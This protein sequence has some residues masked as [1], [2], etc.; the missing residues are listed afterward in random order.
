MTI[1]SK[2]V[3]A[4]LGKHILADGYEPVMDMEKSHGSW[5]V[6]ERDG[7][8]YLDMFSMFASGAVGYNHPDILAGKDRLAAAALYKPTLSDI[9]NVQYAEFVEA[10]SNTAIP[11]YLPHTFFIEG[12]ALGV[13]NA[14][15]VAFDWKVRK[16]MEN[17]KGEKGGKI[18]HFKQ[19][20][21]GRTGYT[22]SL[23][24][25]TDPRK[26]M[27]FPKFDWPRIDIPKLSFPITDIVLENVEKNE[28]IAIDQIKSAISNNPDDIAALIIEPIQGEGGDN[29]FRDNFFV[30]LRQ[31]CDENEMLFIMDEVQTGIGITG[32]WWAHQHNSVKPDIIS[33]GKKTQVCGLLAGKRVEEVDKNVFSESSRINSTFGGNLAD[34]V[35][36]HIILEIIEKENLIENAKNMGAVLKKELQFLSE[37][38]PAYVTNPRGLGL[39]AAFDLPSQTERDKVID[40]LLK[41]KLLMLPS[42]DD[43]IRFRPHLNVTSEDLKTSID[44]IK[45][46]IK[47]TL[48]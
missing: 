35:R 40:G 7:S 6:D 27:Y 23:T 29:H 28:K 47:A 34:M 30:A 38:F 15:K 22:L 36:F 31:L 11:E 42:G 32:K 13:E 21:H 43:A 46:T 48:N 10:F 24:N 14:L 4:T 9:Y 1:D 19:A 2:N 20:F 5:L 8:E 41:N 45:S 44:I 3:R 16:N 39:F 17:G 25:T 18:I 37:E 33:F 26:T 12:G